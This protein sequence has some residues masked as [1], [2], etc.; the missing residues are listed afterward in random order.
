MKR[1]EWRVTLLSKRTHVVLVILV[2][3]TAGMLRC[4]A[5]YAAIGSQVP[6][7]TAPAAPSTEGGALEAAANK[8]SSTGR[9]VAITLIGLAFAVSGIVLAFRRN[10]REAAGVFV[11]GGVA[12]LLA[13]PAGLHLVQ[14]TVTSLFGS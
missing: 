4:D 14:D 12:V 3:A 7:Q 8:A 2:L 11:V 9:K 10:F 6:A 5:A 1:Y 13:T